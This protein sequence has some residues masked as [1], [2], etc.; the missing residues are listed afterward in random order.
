MFATSAMYANPAGFKPGFLDFKAHTLAT[1][2]VV[3]I[4]EAFK[5][6]FSDVL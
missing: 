5:S 4:K 2:A 6:M 1:V 3:T